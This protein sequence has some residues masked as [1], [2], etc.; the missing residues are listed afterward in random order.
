MSQPQLA[1]DMT[2]EP[3]SLRIGDV[4]LRRMSVLE[5]WL[6]RGFI[7]KAERAA[8]DRFAADY[9][10]SR[11]APRYATLA[12]HRV[13]NARR[14]VSADALDRQR[15]AYAS[16][17]AALAAVGPRAAYAL[18]HVVGLNESVR[19]L[20]G[21]GLQAAAL[22]G[23]LVGALAVLVRHFEIDSV[24]GGGGRNR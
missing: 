14:D 10:A 23:L 15:K 13:D 17:M 24:E 6:A 5:Q 2:I 21:G 1:P 9:E 18:E 12:L 8:G 7:T 22:R 3:A 19:D 4:R 20:A 16:C 11:M